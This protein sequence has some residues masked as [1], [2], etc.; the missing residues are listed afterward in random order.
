MPLILKDNGNGVNKVSR[1]KNGCNPQNTSS[2]FLE[3]QDAE[4]QDG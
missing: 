4:F 1:S 2:L 3:V